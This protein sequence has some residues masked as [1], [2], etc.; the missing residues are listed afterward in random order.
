MKKNRHECAFTVFVF[1][2]A[3]TWTDENGVEWN[4]IVR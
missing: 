2:G 4:K 3:D 1:D